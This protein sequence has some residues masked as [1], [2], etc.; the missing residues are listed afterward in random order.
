VV[1]LVEFMAWTCWASV[2]G[3]ED[4]QEVISLLRGQDPCLVFEGDGLV[5]P[6]IRG[7][8]E[9]GRGRCGKRWPME[10]TLPRRLCGDGLRL[11]EASCDILFLRR[12]DLGCLGSKVFHLISVVDVWQME[13]QRQLFRVRFHGLQRPTAVSPA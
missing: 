5:G 7:D 12:D 3:G 9:V 2:H 6:C 4:E 8:R 13:G 10:V 1:Q 11:S